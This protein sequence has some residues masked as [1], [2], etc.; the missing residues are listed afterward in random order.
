[1]PGNGAVLDLRRPFPEGDGIDAIMGVPRAGDPPLGSQMQRSRKS[2]C[3]RGGMKLPFSNPHCSNC[4][5]HWQS[6]TS[7]LRPGTCLRCRAF[8]SSTVKRLSKML[9]IGFQNTPVD[10]MATFVTPS[11]ASQSAIARRSRVI[12]P[13]VACLA[14]HATVRFDSTHTGFDRLFMHIQ[15]GTASKN[16]LHHP[17]LSACARGHRKVKQSAPRA[18]AEAR[19]QFGVR[20]DAQARL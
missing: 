9:K 8:T 18:L 7:L 17:L 5:I 19:R 3:A 12:V 6:R 13:P 20:S 4:A 2:R 10:S 14:M 15:T 11:A 16:V 1:M